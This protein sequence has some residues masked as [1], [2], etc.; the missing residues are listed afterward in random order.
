MVKY[1]TVRTAPK[2]NRKIA[3]T[4]KIDTTN[5]HIYDRSFSCLDTDI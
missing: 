3:E 1:N 4:G 2:C 5:T